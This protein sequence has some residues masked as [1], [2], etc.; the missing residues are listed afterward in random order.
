MATLS[1]GVSNSDVTF[2]TSDGTE[3]VIGDYALIESE[4]VYI[5]NVVSNTLTVVRPTTGNVAHL[6]GVTIMPYFNFKVKRQ[7]DKNIK[8]INRTIEYETG[9]VQT[10]GVTVNPI[11]TWQ[12]TLSGVGTEY[13]RACNFFNARKGSRK[14]F[15]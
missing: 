7:R 11:I 14:Y 1:T 9:A 3:F 6:S 4:I 8:W 5:S 2:I 12:L 13:D 15:M 10:Q